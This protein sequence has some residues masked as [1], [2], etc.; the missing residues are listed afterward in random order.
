MTWAEKVIVEANFSFGLHT[1]TTAAAE[2][3]VWKMNS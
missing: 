3:P 1:S 2:T